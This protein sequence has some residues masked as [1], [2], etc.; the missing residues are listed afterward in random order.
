MRGCKEGPLDLQHYWP[1]QG[2]AGARGP[3]TADGRGSAER[4]NRT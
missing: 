3:L 2:G 1:S 4:Q